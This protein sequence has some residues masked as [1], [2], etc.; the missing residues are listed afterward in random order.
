MKIKVDHYIAKKIAQAAKTAVNDCIEANQM[1]LEFSV[2]D[3]K[4]KVKVGYAG[5]SMT[6]SNNTYHY[7]V[8]LFDRIHLVDHALYVK[9]NGFEQEIERTVMSAIGAMV[10]QERGP[11]HLAPRIS[12]AISTAMSN[13]TQ[14]TT[15]DRDGELQIEMTYQDK[16]DNHQFLVTVIKHGEIVGIYNN[17][18]P[19]QKAVTPTIT[20]VYGLLLQ[21]VGSFQ[22]KN[23]APFYITEFTTFH[24]QSML[25][26][27][28]HITAMTNNN[29]IP[30]YAFSH[31]NQQGYG[32]GMNPGYYSGSADPSKFN[33]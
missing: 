12:S 21:T 4:G 3:I 14:K 27:G 13:P 20:G 11:Q 30:G 24:N 15:F 17:Y 23:P 26:G 28:S 33:Y 22:P 2:S 31:G 7:S 32:P 6:S 9:C 16:A 10:N 25:L 1:S 5:G 18:G 8:S 19:D 29:Q